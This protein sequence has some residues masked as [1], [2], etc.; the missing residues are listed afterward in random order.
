MNFTKV[1]SKWTV[2]EFPMWLSRIGG[3]LGALG[4]R[5]HPRPAQWVEDLVLP[6][7]WLRLQLQLRCDAWQPKRK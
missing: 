1:I 5:F 7:L 2:K 3:V 6:Q 4:R